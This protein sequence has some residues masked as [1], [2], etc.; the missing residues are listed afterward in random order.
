MSYFASNCPV[1]RPLGYKDW[2]ADADFNGILWSD[3]HGFMFEP[4]DEAE[5]I[6]LPPFRRGNR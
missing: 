4:E 1:S 5:P 6:T 2:V 3:K